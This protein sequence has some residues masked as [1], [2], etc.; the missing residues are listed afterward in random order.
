ML[1]VDG[2]VCIMVSDRASILSQGA[3]T[4][5]PEATSGAERTVEQDQGSW[6]GRE[7]WGQGSSGPLA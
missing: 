4:H 6:A 1:E 7:G 5:L 3:S 2:E